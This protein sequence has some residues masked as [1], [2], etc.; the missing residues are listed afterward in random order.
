MTPLFTLKG[1][2]NSMKRICVFCGSSHGANGLYT[3]A[4][5]QMGAALAQ[6]GLTLVYGGGH[7][8]LMGVVADAVLAGGGAVTGVI[9]QALMDKELAHPSLT[10]L[11]VTGSM[12]E[13]KAKMAE[14]ADGFIALPGGFGTYD[15]FCEIVTWAQLGFHRK[16]VGLLN[17][18]G[19]YDGLL[20]FFN[21]ATAEGFIR[22]QHRDMI[23]VRDDVNRLLD[24][25]ANYQ[26]AH[27]HK[28]V[29]RDDL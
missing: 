25:L 12:H 21:H 10:E 23:Q 26:P 2:H 19:F 20:A 8:G 9:P 28:W 3:E 4:A 22:E 17:I 13:R 15:E 7:V 27:V 24:A 1:Q 29:G 11:H 16:P 6:R 18:A 14:L 5:Q